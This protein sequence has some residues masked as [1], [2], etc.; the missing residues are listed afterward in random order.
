ML[1]IPE[2]SA[3]VSKLEAYTTRRRELRQQGSEGLARAYDKQIIALSSAIERDA[4][5]RGS[6]GLFAV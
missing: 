1:T 3:L 2:H 4:A 6:R 5:Q